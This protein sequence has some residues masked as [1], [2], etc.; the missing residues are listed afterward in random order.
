MRVKVLSDL[1][2]EFSD[3]D[4]GSGD[5]L[6]LAGDICQACAYV[7]RG[8]ELYAQRYDAFFKKCVENYNKVFYVM[9][10]HEHYNGYWGETEDILRE[11]LPEGITLLQNQSE[12]YNGWHF[13]GATLWTNFCGEKKESMDVCLDMLNE[14]HYVWHNDDKDFRNITPANTLAENK[15][16]VAWLKQCLPTLRGNVMVISHHPPTFESIEPDYVHKDTIGAYASDQE[17]L[18]AKHNN[19]LVWAH[20]HI[21]GSQSYKLHG[22]HI[23]CNPRGYITDEIPEGVNPKFDADRQLNLIDYETST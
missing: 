22:T 2:L 23:V 18:L 5:V 7:F 14:Y 8:E 6:V 13:V 1:H 10:N 12:F 9:G 15:N 21:H 3:F 4:P 19:L 20:G 17:F 11:F 16:T